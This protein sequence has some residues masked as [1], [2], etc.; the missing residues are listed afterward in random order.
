MQEIYHTLSFVNFR[1]PLSVI[2]SKLSHLSDLKSCLNLFKL[3]VVSNLKLL[4]SFSDKIESSF[5]NLKGKK[6]GKNR[7]NG[8]TTHYQSSLLQGSGV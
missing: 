7:N 2:S 5:L 1:N 6:S 3:P 8:E 4:A